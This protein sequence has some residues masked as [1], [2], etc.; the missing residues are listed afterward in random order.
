[1][2]LV[3]WYKE[4]KSQHSFQVFDRK[5]KCHDPCV[6]WKSEIHINSLTIICFIHFFRMFFSATCKQNLF[7]SFNLLHF[8]NLYSRLKNSK[9]FALYLDSCFLS[10]WWFKENPSKLKRFDQFSLGNKAK[11]IVHDN[12]PIWHI[13][14]IVYVCT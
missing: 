14:K 6:T 12:Y 13:M 5:Q 2:I 9:L 4:N 3:Q 10:F 11:K 1:M 8:T 7:I